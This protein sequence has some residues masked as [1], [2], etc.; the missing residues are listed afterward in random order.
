MKNIS[1]IS[2]TYAHALKKDFTTDG[3]INTAYNNKVSTTELKQVILEVCKDCAKT[4]AY[5][6]FEV[7][8]N[9]CK[10]RESII[11]LV[12]NAFLKG[13]GLGII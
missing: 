6:K 4:P 5:N 9:N 12:Y 7:T 10:T 11:G 13:S 1:N 3:I 8:L 2:W